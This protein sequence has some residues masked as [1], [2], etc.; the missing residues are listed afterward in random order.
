MFAPIHAKI[1][2][3][4][5]DPVIIHPMR[6]TLRAEE[7]RF[8]RFA[9]VTVAHYSHLLQSKEGKKKYIR[10][11]GGNNIFT[12]RTRTIRDTY[13]SYQRQRNDRFL[14]PMWK[15]SLIAS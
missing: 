13:A 6:V 14:S 4:E 11:A 5:I 7:L 15:R 9:R 12:S 3:T 10:N 8:K 1:D 2:D